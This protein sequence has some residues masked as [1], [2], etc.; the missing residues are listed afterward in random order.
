MKI[1]EKQMLSEN[2]NQI[3]E[4]VDMNDSCITKVYENINNFNNSSLQALSYENDIKF[5]DELSFILSVI[6]S[7]VARPTINVTVEDVVLRQDQAPAIQPEHYQRIF[8][9]IKLWKR[10][11]AEMMP[12]YV[13]YSQSIDKI[14]T[15]EN[16]FVAMLI[17][18]IDDELTKYYD[19]YVMQLKTFD[20]NVKNSLTADEAYEALVKIEKLFKRIKYIKNSYF[21]KRVSKVN[22]KLENILLCIMICV[23][24]LKVLKC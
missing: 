7:I 24:V 18:K 22:F 4:F 8:K 10:K 13:H 15:Y 17:K 5:L 6:A 16:C 21:Y 20:R 12:E 3:K 1:I 19:F 9:D 14:E 23:K 11:K 2:I